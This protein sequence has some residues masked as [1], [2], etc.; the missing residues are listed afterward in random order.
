MK[1]IF[2]RKTINKGDIT[3]NIL[4]IYKRAKSGQ[5]IGQEQFDFDV[6]FTTATMLSEKYGIKYDPNNPV[7]AD[8]DLADRVFQ[9]GVEFFSKVGVYCTDTHK[10]IRFSDDEINEALSNIKENCKIGEGKDQYIFRSRY[11]DSA[12]K[13]WYH[14][15]SGIMNTDERIAFNLV[16]SYANIPQT[17]SISAPALI[18]INGQQILSDTPSEIY[19]AI[20]S[21]RI[22]REAT[23]HSGRSGLGICNCIS[24]AGSDVGTISASASQFG[25]RPSDGWLIAI[26]SEMKINMSSMNK[27]A[28]LANW[29]ANVA[30]E[31]G[32]LLGGF[33]GGPAETAIIA[34]ASLIL[35]VIAFQCDYYL[36]FPI[37]IAHGCSTNRQA[38]WSSAVGAQAI[39]RNTKLPVL[40]LGYV[41][42]GPMT[43]QFFYETLAY[44]ATVISSGVS[45]QTTHPVKA[46]LNDYVTPLEM[47]GS[48]RLTES[49]VGMNRIEANE[50]VKELLSKYENNL[51]NAPIGV[52]YQDCYDINTNE[53]CQEY[54]DLFNEVID[55]LRKINIR[56]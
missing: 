10:V 5:S 46:V 41:A 34:V 52:K 13:T 20:R 18:N 49:C 33:A 36:C 16:S 35:G 56:L 48:V 19:G 12:I 43:K 28:Y 23:R 32:P 39:S 25:L 14:V 8:N 31:C 17:N 22:A 15:G 47:L 37:S 44:V 1:P 3:I 11:P 45:A 2:V 26:L 21:I 27:L 29:G 30:A 42:S 51:K 7:P 38:I 9:A 4:D 40:Y 24:T 55:E 6:V 53:P 54:M 50:I